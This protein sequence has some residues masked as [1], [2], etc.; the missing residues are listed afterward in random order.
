MT[1]FSKSTLALAALAGAL[2]VNIRISHA[3][4]TGDS[5][6]CA[7]TNK[8]ADTMSCD[9][10]YESSDE[11]ARAIRW[12]WR[13]RAINPYWRTLGTRRA[14]SYCVEQAL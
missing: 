13:L 10:E 6:W 8:G 2:C 11:C 7:V 4:Q 12:Q 3:Y 14:S 9:C 1:R 5:R